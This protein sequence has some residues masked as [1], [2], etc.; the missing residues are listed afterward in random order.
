MQGGSHVKAEEKKKER[1]GGACRS[2]DID[3]Q[4]SRF[5]V[6]DHRKALIAVPVSPGRYRGFNPASLAATVLC[7]PLITAPCQAPRRP[8]KSL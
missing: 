5:L 6:R 4:Q 8:Q 3:V 2:Q 1:K 7:Q